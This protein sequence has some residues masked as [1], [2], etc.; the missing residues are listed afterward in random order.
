MASIRMLFGVIWVAVFASS[1]AHAADPA[2]QKLAAEVQPLGWIAFSA[3]SPTGDWDLFLSR[4]D[5]SN[6]RPLTSTPDYNEAGVR[7]SPD[8][9]KIL[10]YR[11][12]KSEPVDNNTYGTF[13]LVLA[14]STGKNPA[15]WGDKF[16][17]AT[18]S[19]D[20]KQLACLNPEGVIIVDV[21]T[22]KTLRTITRKGLVEQL[23]W[24]P[25]GAAFT[26]TANG[27]G[28]YWNIG[29]LDAKTGALTAISETDRYNCTSDW[30]PDGKHVVYARGIIPDKPGRAELWMAT[31]DGKERKTI[32]AEPER[33]IYG[34]CASP[35]GK[36]VIFTRSEPDLGQVELGKTLM[37]IVRVADAGDKNRPRLDLTAGW[38]P[39][40]TAADLG[41]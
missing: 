4:P 25:D 35:D 24:S 1:L 27:L 21:A 39:H 20:G 32:Y 17:W 28:P 6:R 10:Y 14:D 2:T 40:W 26:G 30:M 19:P 41:K 29:R 36:Y 33:H 13:E 23:V 11:L 16:H 15:V 22:R 31:P 38:E 34:A 8:G 5:G 37:A 12:P 7:F 9:K 3:P 18:W